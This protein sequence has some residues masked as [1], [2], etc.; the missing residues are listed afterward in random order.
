MKFAPWHAAEVEF[1][2]KS[3]MKK[4]NRLRVRPELRAAEWSE[5]MRSL[6]VRTF[7][8]LTKV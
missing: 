3:R 1:S 5:V 6:T 4:P 8:K 7:P 2:L